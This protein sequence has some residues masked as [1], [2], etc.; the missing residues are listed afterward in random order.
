[1]QESSDLGKYIQRRIKEKKLDKKAIADALNISVSTVS[2]IYPNKD[3]YSDRLA[4]F[5]ILLNEDLFLDYYGQ[6][7]PLKTILNREKQELL[8]KIELLQNDNREKS[9]LIDLLKS[10]LNERNTTIETLGSMLL[11]KSNEILELLKNR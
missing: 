6:N 5:C 4:K 7:D 2:K 3:I 8:N 11:D 1:M 10:Q 9:D